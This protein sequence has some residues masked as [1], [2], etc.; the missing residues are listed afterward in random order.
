VRGHGFSQYAPPFVAA[1]F[2]FQI[3]RC[4][5]KQGLMQRRDELGGDSDFRAFPAGP[6]E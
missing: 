2:R 4:G 5:H 1:K 6:A 3:E